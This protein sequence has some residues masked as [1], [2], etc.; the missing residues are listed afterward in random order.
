MAAHGISHST[1][2][3][4]RPLPTIGDEKVDQDVRP[5]QATQLS[6]A[7]DEATAD[8]QDTSDSDDQDPGGEKELEVQADTIDRPRPPRPQPHLQPPEPGAGADARPDTVEPLVPAGPNAASSTKHGAGTR[9]TTDTDAEKQ[10]KGAIAAAKPA[11]AESDTGAGDAGA[12]NKSCLPFRLNKN[13]PRKGGKQKAK[14]AL[15]RAFEKLSMGL[16]SKKKKEAVD[17]NPYAAPPTA[18][19]QARADI[20]QGRA[21]GVPGGLPSNPRMN[22]FASSTAPPPYQSPSV[23]S[24]S[25][26]FG[27]EKYGNQN[28]YGSNRYDNDNASAFSS[29]QRRPGGYG[30]L[31]DGAENNE[32][33]GGAAGRYVP[34]QPGANGANG[35]NGS[36]APQSRPSRYDNDPSKNTLLGNAQDRYN[37]MPQAQG[38]GPAADDEYGGYGAPR[39]MTEEERDREETRAINAETR[40]VRKAGVDSVNRSIAAGRQALAFATS[41]SAR[42]A[43]QDNRLQRAERNVDT[44]LVMSRESEAKTKELNKINSSMFSGMVGPSKKTL[45]KRDAAT[46]EQYQR[47]KSI[48]EDTAKD[49]YR[50]EQQ[51]ETMFNDLSSSRTPG[52]LGAKRNGAERSKFVFQDDDDDD[53]D[54]KRLAQEDQDDEDQ[55]DDGVDE[56][57][58]IS[59]K[60]KGAAI[61][62]GGNLT[63]QNERLDRLGGKI[64]AVDDRVRMNREKL[65][66]IR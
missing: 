56:L 65:S 58:D 40:A 24:D 7:L 44:A 52:S 63:T 53:E 10:R 30:G 47:D 59:R 35:A 66:R 20:A 16:F 42:L 6:T 39:E 54:A 62:M 33:F 34:P 37:P 27:D 45:N 36:P 8:Q 48:R 51:M 60:L 2:V 18:L 50:S 49:G 32:L 15:G 19:Q 1:T 61:G 38:Q 55:I 21:P 29:N 43:E 31:G 23:A 25:N 11:D 9:K 4:S 28:G 26:R 3:D 57:M 64:D 46:L 17:E 13:G 12:D 14:R 41:T 5:G 22:S